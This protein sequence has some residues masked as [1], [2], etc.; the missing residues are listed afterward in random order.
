MSTE[1]TKLEH[2]SNKQTLRLELSVFLGR[3]A[4]EKRQR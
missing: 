4:Q 3:M 1:I 2:L